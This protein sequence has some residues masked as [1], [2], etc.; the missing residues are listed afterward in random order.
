[1]GKS[2]EVKLEDLAAVIA[3]TVK[4][5]RPVK[6]ALRLVQPP[7]PALFDEVTRTC[8]LDRIRRLRRMWQLGWLVEQATFNKAGIDA[9][10]DPELAALLKDLERARECIEEGIPFADA[11]L[12]RNMADELPE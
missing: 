11:D 2:T 5:V 4:G 8:V 7:P 12:V 1:L 3:S 9:L 10:S 6:P